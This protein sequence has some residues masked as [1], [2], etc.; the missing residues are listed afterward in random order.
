MPTSSGSSATTSTLLRGG[1]LGLGGEV[2]DVLVADGVV[3][4]IA[5]A[6]RLEAPDGAEVVE[7]GDA[8]VL[9]GLVDGHVHVEQWVRHRRSVDLAPA[10]GPEEAARLLRAH[11][12]AHPRKP[13]EVLSGRDLVPALWDEPPHK[14][15]LDAVLGDVPVLVRSIDLHTTWVNSAALALLGAAD[16]PTGVLRETESMQAN[17][18]MGELT[19]D[20]E[21]DRWVA[22]ALAGLPSVGLTALID[23]EFTDNLAVWPRRAARGALPLRVHAGIWTPWLD[24]AIA[25]GRRTGD[26]LEGTD[27]LVHVG[28]YKIVSDGSLNTRTAWCVDAYPGMPEGPEAHGLCLVPAA[29]LEALMRKA[30]AAGLQP[31]I[32]A[33][34]DQ[35]NTEVLDTFERIGC[36]GRI[37]HAQLVRAEDIARFGRLGVIA[38]V[39]PQHAMTDRDVADRHWAGR[40]DRAFAY[41]SLHDAGARLELGSDAPVSPPDPWEAV[42]DAVHRTG[43]GRPAWHP[44]QALPLDV[45]ITA[46]CG[47]R[48]EVT[49]GSAADLTVVAGDPRE[50][51][52][53]D[54]RRTDVVAT[55]V[56]GTFTHRKR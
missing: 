29:E 33:I 17:A 38:S 35:A 54:L 25:A 22:D 47:G 56:A 4:A 36:T 32:H 7:L 21:V 6:G 23:L 41:R 51:S 45:A 46:A 2:S 18:R 9:P 40:T 42:A 43:D 27:G 44:E 20:E 34:G 37:E 1:R 28:P 49:I 11:L 50:F 52:E 16:H 14:D 24:A 5:P 31:A 8:T 39:Q 10:R 15:H 55:L 26:V 53:T 30:W 12:D 19:P 3:A 13:G 48:A